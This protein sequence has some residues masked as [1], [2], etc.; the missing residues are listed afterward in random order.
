MRMGTRIRNNVCRWFLVFQPR[1][2]HASSVLPLLFAGRS[3]PDDNYLFSDLWILAAASFYASKCYRAL[4]IL[5]SVDLWKWG[6][7]CC[8]GREPHTSNLLE[9]LV[10]I[11]GSLCFLACKS[12]HDGYVPRSPEKHANWLIF[13][14]RSVFC[15]FSHAR[16]CTLCSAGLRL[17]SPIFRSE[18]ES[19]S[20]IYSPK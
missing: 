4:R 16:N 13:A 19:I 14:F 1:I 6:G 11:L 8:E 12:R 7:L 20:L 3:E 18:K 5:S 10:A 17:H 2:L 9:P 15:W